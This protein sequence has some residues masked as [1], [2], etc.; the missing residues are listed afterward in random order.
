MVITDSTINRYSYC[1]RRMMLQDIVW[2]FEK[3]SEVDVYL[4]NCHSERSEES[5]ISDIMKV[6]I[7]RSATL[8]ITILSA[9]NYRYRIII[10]RNKFPRGFCKVPKCNSFRLLIPG[11]LNIGGLQAQMIGH[12]FELDRLTI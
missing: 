9:V 11:E 6:Q 4:Q 3:F 7:L 8:R 5:E 12:F 10:F 2:K 1:L